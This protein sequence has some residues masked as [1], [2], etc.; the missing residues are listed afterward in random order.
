MIVISVASSSY[1]TY[2]KS[3][4]GSL[5]KN[6]PYIKIH[7]WL[8]NCSKEEGLEIKKF[9]SNC[10]IHHENIQF[11]NNEQL[12]CYCTNKRAELF[13]MIKKSQNKVPENEAIMWIDADSLVLKPF[14]ELLRLSKIHDVILCPRRDI[15]EIVDENEV[16]PEYRNKKMSRFLGGFIVLGATNNSSIFAKQYFKIVDTSLWRTVSDVR[17]EAWDVWMSNQ[18]ALESVYENLKDSLSF[19]FVPRTYCDTSFKENSIIWAAKSNLKYN[20]VY[21]KKMQE[22]SN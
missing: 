7:I 16:I 22:F 4:I 14:D 1:I 5:K 8:I 20:D 18:T 17:D 13:R 21:I 9:N 19:H 11:E 2:I 3:M 6:M 10:E 12:R 15:N